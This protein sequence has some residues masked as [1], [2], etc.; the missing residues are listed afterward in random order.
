MKRWKNCVNK[1]LGEKNLTGHEV[2]VHNR[3]VWKR[4]TRNGDPI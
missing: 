4:L 2:Q 1:D 3:A